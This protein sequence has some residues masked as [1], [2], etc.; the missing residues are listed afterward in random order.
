M[1]VY[2]SPVFMVKESLPGTVTGWKMFNLPVDSPEAG[3]LQA[4]SNQSWLMALSN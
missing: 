3:Q 4:E 1:C 2:N